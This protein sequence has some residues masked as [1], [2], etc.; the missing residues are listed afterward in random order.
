QI[1]FGGGLEEGSTGG[2]DSGHRWDGE[3]GSSCGAPIGEQGFLVAKGGALEK[4][5]Q[6]DAGKAVNL[7]RQVKHGRTRVCDHVRLAVAEFQGGSGIAQLGGRSGGSQR[8][9]QKL[10]T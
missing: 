7:F 8:R 3:C 1:F 9:K 2:P 5:L 6:L 4:H 10:S